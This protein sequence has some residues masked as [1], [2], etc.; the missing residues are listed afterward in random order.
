MI[1]MLLLAAMASEQY[2]IAAA[3]METSASNNATDAAQPAK[4]TTETKIENEN[5]SDSDQANDDPEKQ[6]KKR[7]KQLKKLEKAQKKEAQKAAKEKDEEVVNNQRE[8]TG[9]IEKGAK[10]EGSDKQTSTKTDAA[11]EQLKDSAVKDSTVKDSVVKDSTVKDSTVKDSAVKDSTVKELGTALGTVSKE[12]KTTA[13]NEEARDR[14]VLSAFMPDSALLSVLKDVSKELKEAQA[15]RS[16]DDPAQRTV[17]DLVQEVMSKALNDAKLAPNR[18]VEGRGQDGSMPAMTTESWASGDV[19][20]SSSCHSSLA[21]VWAKRENGLLNITIVGR[22]LDRSTPGGKQIGEFVVIVNGRSSVEHGFDIQS[23]SNVHF[24]L[25]KISA[26]TVESDCNEVRKTEKK[27]S[28]N[29]SPATSPAALQAAFLNDAN[30][31][32]MV[33]PAVLTERGRKY[34]AMMNDMAKPNHD[35]SDQPT[36]AARTSSFVAS[37][38]LA[39]GMT[40]E[41]LEKD[42]QRV[43]TEL[44][45]KQKMSSKQEGSS[46]SEVSS[47][48]TRFDAD[49]TAKLGVASA[50]VLPSRKPEPQLSD[51]NSQKGTGQLSFSAQEG[52]IHL[53]SMDAFLIAPERAL[54]GQPITVIV[55]D[56][57]RNGEAFVELSLNGKTAV[58]DING[59]HT[60]IVPEDAT[61]GHSLNVT[62]AARPEN[63]PTTVEIFQPLTVSAEKQPPKIE[64]VVPI[65]SHLNTIIVDGHNFDGLAGKDKANLDGQFQGRILAASPVQ[66]RINLPV[67]LQAGDHTL[68]VTCEGMTSNSVSFH[69]QAT[70]S[71]QS[72]DSKKKPL[73]LAGSSRIVKRRVPVL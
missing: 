48:Q 39:N 18:I 25:G 13:K 23:Q 44:S 30:R 19:S 65:S 24:W 26:V 62:L 12:Q 32:F 47:N 17:I 68:F 38:T 15:T 40:L 28:A 52:S 36:M 16:I 54:A 14:K 60:F 41:E 61:P 56:G 29:T 21:A 64:R 59:Q 51:T 55:M 34:S 37:T 35:S 5:Q 31:E 53:P 11:A 72:N 27:T 4:T 1:S 42:Y 71:A 57:K 2:A 7:L 49:Q 58:T 67:N 9:D 22:C 50:F 63:S 43:L 20:L 33:L 6:E 45:S 70:T 73:K 3:E 10:G 8:K 66:L 69:V 46:K